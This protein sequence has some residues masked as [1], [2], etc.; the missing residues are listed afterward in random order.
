MKASL[1]LPLLKQGIHFIGQIRKDSALFLP[2][3]RS[4]KP[5][6]PRKYGIKLSFDLICQLFELQ[7]AS[8]FAYGNPKVGL[9]VLKTP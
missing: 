2:P 8:I 3:V 6:R 7:T 5:G 1:V 4:L 9:Y